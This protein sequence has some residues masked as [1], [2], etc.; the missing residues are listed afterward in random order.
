[1]GKAKWGEVFF[2]SGETY[3][4]QRRQRKR[5]RNRFQK[6]HKKEKTKK[7]WRLQNQ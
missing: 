7:Q 4:K 1:M 3:I 5:T 6:I 2:W